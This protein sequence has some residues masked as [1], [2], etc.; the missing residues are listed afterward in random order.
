MSQEI[1]HISKT[2]PSLDKGMLF[3][4]IGGIFETMVTAPLI[5]VGLVIVSLAMPA[6][7]SLGS[8]R[9]LDLTINPD[10]ST[11]ISSE[12]IVD[13]ENLQVDLFGQSIDNLVAVDDRGSQLSGTIV[14]DKAIFDSISSSNITVSYDIH[15]LVSKQDRVWTFLFDSPSE[16]SLLM[17]ENSVIIEMSVPPK[18]DLVGEQ[19]RLELPSGPTQ[20]NYIFGVNTNPPDP[21][22]E[23]HFDLTTAGL[24]AG[25][26]IAAVIGASIILIKRQRSSPQPAVTRTGASPPDPKTIFSLRPEMREDDKNIV[27]FIHD[28]GGR[29]LESDLR[30]KFLQ[31][32]TTMWRAVKRLERL[33]I[34][35]IYK[36]D[37]Q[38]M[39]KLREELEDEN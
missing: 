11:H 28:S 20:I 37:L 33:G 30:K 23:Q 31:P 15:D 39:V 26:I 18:I 24:V 5:F 8:A 4:R 1:P 6:Q 7:A 10:G 3:V 14:G 27:K 29:V 32:R 13:S 9:T 16:Y 25:P 21:P 17:P 35:E 2:V 19:V 22:E 34:V 36:K 38:N 12:F